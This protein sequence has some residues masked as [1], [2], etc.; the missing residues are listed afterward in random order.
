MK[1]SLIPEKCIACGLCQTYS[2]VFDYD[3]EGIV[4]FKD[5]DQLSLIVEDSPDTLI[6]VK[7][8]PTKALS[9]EV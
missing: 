7:S 2:P 9:C 3:D 6:A 5:S 4:R 8:C 1:V